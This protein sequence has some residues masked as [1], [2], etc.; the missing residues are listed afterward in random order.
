MSIEAAE[1]EQTERVVLPLFDTSLGL[2]GVR[3]DDEFILEAFQE[4]KRTIRLK[5]LKYIFSISKKFS[6]DL[7][8]SAFQLPCFDKSVSVDQFEMILLKAKHSSQH[9]D[10]SRYLFRSCD[11]TPFRINGTYCFEAFIERGDIIEIGFNRI[12][13]LRSNTQLKMLKEKLPLPSSIIES[14]LSLLIEGETGTGKTTLAKYVHE[15][16]GRVGRFV[17]L[18][19]SAFSTNLIES[20]LFGH[21]KGAFTGAN[22]SKT[23]AILEAHKG[24]LFLDEIDSLS[25][26]LQTKL[27]LFLDNFE[28]RAVGG[29]NSQKCDVRLIFASGRSLSK[30]VEN[31]KMRQDFYFRL[32]SG[33]SVKLQSLN[34]NPDKIVDICRQ[35]EQENFVVLSDELINFYQRCKWPG[36][37]RQLHSHLKKKL[38]LS[39]G[40]KMVQDNLDYDLLITPQ[41]NLQNSNDKIKTLERIKQDYCQSL[42]IK[43][44]SNTKNVAE[45]LDISPNTL[46]AILNSCKKY[47]DAIK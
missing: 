1:I 29:N 47:Q 11:Q 36:N 3:E 15:Q 9:N 7:S 2:N 45:L 30:L 26:E 27:L 20:E 31:E 8:K 6:Y 18:N 13:F 46:K 4:R 38:V 33:S 14:Q 16:S 41:L 12:Q 34:E 23:G 32:T 24:T 21:V 43:F 17:H 25:L 42:F 19:L 22:N 40:K 28:V 5:R 37:I 10:K 44:G 39:N 35:F